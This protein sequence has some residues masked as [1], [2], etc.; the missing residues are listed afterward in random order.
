MSQEPPS[1]MQCAVATQRRCSVSRGQRFYRQLRLRERTH[2]C[3]LS[4]QWSV[5]NVG[6]VFEYPR[7]QLS[8]ARGRLL[9]ANQTTKWL[10]EA[11]VLACFS[12]LIPVTAFVAQAGY[13]QHFGIPLDCMPLEG[14]IL[15]SRAF[16]SLTTVVVLFAFVTT[17][18]WISNLLTN[19]ISS[20]RL[21]KLNSWHRKASPWKRGA[22]VVPIVIVS[23]LPMW[24]GISQEERSEMVDVGIML[25]TFYVT[26]VSIVFVTE[27]L[28]TSSEAAPVSSTT[29]A[30]DPRSPL[31]RVTDFH[32]RHRWYLGFLLT[33][34]VYLYFLYDTNVHEAERR[35]Y[36]YV[37]NTGDA[38]PPVV[39]VAFMGENA[40]G[41][42]FDSE[43]TNGSRTLRAMRVVKL[44]E[45]PKSSLEWTDLGPLRR[46]PTKKAAQHVPRTTERTDAP[47][48]TLGANNLCECV[49]QDQMFS[50]GDVPQENVPYCAVAP[51]R[52]TSE[53]RR[54][55]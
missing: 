17:V 36:F 7:P 18:F 13:S 11:L 43:P 24:I 15:V 40:L 50:F 53:N 30:L 41:F 49:E 44:S 31:K 14:M 4:T 2:P 1:L 5:A 37:Y 12:A 10:S 19:T 46:A 39:I 51:T 48:G 9:K 55:H 23:I 6:A 25:L 54:I 28:T 42:T 16:E 27:K 33:L 35:R 34:A 32:H 8:H 3:S 21:D 29:L 26:A 47:S 20:H 52:T 22:V 45:K 38:D